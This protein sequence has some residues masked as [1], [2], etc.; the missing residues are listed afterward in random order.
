M[1]YLQGAAIA[2]KRDP[3]GDQRE[4][5]LEP[6]SCRRLSRLPIDAWKFGLRLI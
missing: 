1:S 3:T 2:P 5:N 4:A 6:A